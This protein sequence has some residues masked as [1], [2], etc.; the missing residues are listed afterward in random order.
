MSARAAGDGFHPSS[1]DPI[2][3]VVTKVQFIQEYRPTS[4]SLGRGASALVEWC[5]SGYVVSIMEQG[6]GGVFLWSIQDIPLQGTQVHVEMYMYG[7]CELR[8]NGRNVD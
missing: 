5:D 2:P 8:V 3:I 7:R 6:C 4:H 1:P